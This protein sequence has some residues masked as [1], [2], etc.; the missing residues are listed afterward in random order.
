MHSQIFYSFQ[1]ILVA[2]LSYRSA[3]YC[4][5]LY[6]VCI[7]T[8]LIVLFLRGR[9]PLLLGLKKSH[10]C[11]S[12]PF[13]SSESEPKYH[14]TG[15]IRFNNRDL[16]CLFLHVVNSSCPFWYLECHPRY[17]QIN[18]SSILALCCSKNFSVSVGYPS[19]MQHSE[20]ACL[21]TNS[22]AHL[23]SFRCVSSLLQ[24]TC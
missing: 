11:S 5:H 18:T 4:Y 10:V 2:L 14:V 9:L 22:E 15:P 6:Y 7:H 17:P 3:N 19:V 16:A 21:S 1:R 24:L 20:I 8:V 23:R 13:C 12:G